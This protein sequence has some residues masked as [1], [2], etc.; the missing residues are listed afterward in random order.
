MKKKILL[1]SIV[2][3][4][5]AFLIGLFIFMNKEKKNLSYF[6]EGV[7]YV[8]TE[9]GNYVIFSII[10]NSLNDGK[11]SYGYYET[12]DKNGKV[13]ES[14]TVKLDLEYKSKHKY[15]VRFKIK[16]L[17]FDKIKFIPLYSDKTEIKFS[18]K[19]SVNKYTEFKVVGYDYTDEKVEFDVIS[20]SNK[21][22]KEIQIVA[23]GK[24]DNEI[25]IEYLDVDIQ[26]EKN[27]EFTINYDKLIGKD[28]L[29]D[30]FKLF[31]R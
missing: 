1:G 31:Y 25:Q 12:K 3:I 28:I 4:I 10:N 29:I 6:I 15:L 8:K 2:L 26:L 5:I 11:I 22:I 19:K 7:S 18:T 21:H 23:Y 24:H 13:L 20:N 14:N 27:G 30:K 16:S 17:D 9:K